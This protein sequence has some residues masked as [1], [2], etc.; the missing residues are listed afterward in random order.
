MV[1]YVVAPV[2]VAGMYLLAGRGSTVAA[3]RRVQGIV[4]CGLPAALV[5]V[6]IASGVAR[7]G[8]WA[9]AVASATPVVI[10]ALLIG[11]AFAWA[12][13]REAPYPTLIA[14]A[15]RPWIC[16]AAAL[17]L[18][19]LIT[20]VGLPLGLVGVASTE[21]AAWY[22]FLSITFVVVVVLPAVLRPDDTS[23][24]HR[25]L[26]GV[27]LRWLGELSYGLYLWHVAVLSVLD[28]VLGFQGR[29]GTHVP[30]LLATLGLSLVMAALSY[31]LVE[32]PVRRLSKRWVGSMTTVARSTG[33]TLTSPAA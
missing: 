10:A 1:F 27:A 17:A 20:Q 18:Y 5:V 6:T 3:R 2:L 22:S 12:F 14:L 29:T 33:S 16:V 25:V 4:L 9:A 13:N 24:Y 7:D 30:L 32:Q 23:R 28:R 31:V 21:G 26:G 15:R 11:G 19:W 8:D